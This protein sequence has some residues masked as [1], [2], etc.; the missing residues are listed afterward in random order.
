MIFET[1]FTYHA[2]VS[3]PVADPRR[4]SMARDE[5]NGHVVTVISQ[6]GQN[7]LVAVP[8]IGFPPGFQ[9]PP[10]A[11][12]VLVSTP[13]GP[14]VRPIARVTRGRVSPDALERR[15]TLN[16]EGR[17][18][19]LQDATVIGEQPSVEGAPEEDIVWVVDPGDAEGPEQVIAV[20]VH[21]ERR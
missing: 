15:E 6:E 18:Q 10:G 21:P 14:G 2:M 7:V 3:Q 13:S 8:M 4:P 20:R 19:V 1:I 16:L 9:L 12:V 11:S 5:E 17:Q